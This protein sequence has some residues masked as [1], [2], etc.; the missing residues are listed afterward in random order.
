MTDLLNKYRPQTWEDVYGN[1][2]AVKA[3]QAAVEKKAGRA[4]LLAGPSGVGK[5]TL[6]RIAA[7]ALGGE[8]VEVVDIDA[9]SNTGIEAMREVCATLQYRPLGSTAK[10]VICDEAHALSKAAVTSLLK[11][12]EEPP[13]WVYWF[14]C[15]TAPGKIPKEIQTRCIPIHLKALT[16][17]QLHALLDTIVAKEEHDTP[18][19]ILW[20]CAEEAGGSA[21]QA[22]AN[23][24]L[25]WNAPDEEQAQKLLRTAR[26]SPEAIELA[27]ALI[28]GESWKNVSVIL[29][30]FAKDNVNPETVRHVMLAYVTKVALNPRGS[31]ARALRV[32]HAFT[33]AFEPGVGIAPLVL[34]SAAACEEE[35]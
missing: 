35:F 33:P 9:A 23:L 32:L 28:G 14:L 11:P 24:V 5:T 29:Q 15:T 18:D 22:I 27:R 8:S 17:N 6:A 16:E 25:C 26:D 13:P 21:R 34:A 7:K 30:G 1:A 20:V 2:E 19:D 12:L 31:P 10:A 3:L 4:Y